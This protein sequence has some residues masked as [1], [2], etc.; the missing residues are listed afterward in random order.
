MSE[1]LLP[2]PFCGAAGRLCVDDDMFYVACSSPTCFCCVG[3]GYDRSA[4]SDHAFSSADGAADAW[5]A[6]ASQWREISDSQKDGNTILGT[7]PE[8]GTHVI[9]WN[10]EPTLGGYTWRISESEISLHEDAITHWQP[11]PQPPVSK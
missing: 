8:I 3:E 4:M 7:G 2:C 1:E 9:W 11:L 5:N 6:R 10:S